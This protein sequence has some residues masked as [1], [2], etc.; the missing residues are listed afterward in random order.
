MNASS[1]T[2]GDLQ[3][4]EAVLAKLGIELPASI[5]PVGNYARARAAGNV[6][7]L[8]GHL[9]DS[10]GVPQFMGKLGRE[11]SVE[12]GYQAAR[13]AMVNT[14]GTIKANLGSLKRVK[15]ITKLLGMVNCV[16]DFVR[17]PEVINGASDLLDEVFGREIALHAR[18]AVGMHSLPRGN[19]VEIE[20]ILEFE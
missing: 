17:Q 3:D 15:R 7:Y 18:S 11:V 10:A 13:V 16:A 12:E 2:T 8:A 4:P 14:L 19:C 20:T 6:L 1:A 9:P 5:P